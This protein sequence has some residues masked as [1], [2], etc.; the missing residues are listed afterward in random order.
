MVSKVWI[1]YVGRIICSLVDHQK[2]S[3]IAIEATNTKTQ[4]MYFF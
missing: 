3:V 2:Q 4:L 1:F